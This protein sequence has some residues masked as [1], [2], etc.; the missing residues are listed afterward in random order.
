MTSVPIF[1][2]G[3]MCHWQWEGSSGD[4]LSFGCRRRH[5]DETTGISHAVYVSQT[6]SG[7]GV[8]AGLNRAGEP[9]ICRTLSCPWDGDGFPQ[10]PGW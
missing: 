6:T 2:S 3:Q 8:L 10:Q 4:S 5:Q 9:W 7:F 1:W